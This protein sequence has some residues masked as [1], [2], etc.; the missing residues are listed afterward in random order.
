MKLNVNTCYRYIQNVPFCSTSIIFN[1]SSVAMG[2]DFIKINKTLRNSNIEQTTEFRL[3]PAPKILS[4]PQR[5][6]DVHSDPK[7]YTSFFEFQS[8]G[9]VKTVQYGG[10]QIPFDIPR[11]ADNTESHAQPRLFREVTADAA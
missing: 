9:R 8:S 2:T 6:V 4:R 5:N 3:K 11:P 1:V 7:F 10:P